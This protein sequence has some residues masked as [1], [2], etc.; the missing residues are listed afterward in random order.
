MNLPMD[1]SA[2]PAFEPGWVWLAG[3]GPG[4]VGLLTLLAAHGLQQADVVVYDALVSDGVMALARDDAVQIYA[5]KRGGRPS[6]RQQDISAQLIE[7]A[8]QGLRVLRLKGGDP[9]VFGR[10]GEEAQALGVAGIPFRI[11]PGVTAGIGALGTAGIPLTHRDVNQAV[12]FITGHTDNPEGTTSLDWQA[13]ARSAPVLVIYMGMRRLEAIAQNLLN[14]GKP[15]DEPVA[16]ISNATLPDQHILETTLSLAAQDA[17]AHG[18]TPPAIIVIGDVV[19]L[20][21][22]LRKT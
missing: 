19:P 14:A 10:G 7:R 1:F 13:L 6:C 4:D 12:T 18:L 3:A 21:T 2:F 15:P 11:I 16:I 17:S 20:R 8:K 5:G 22:H 9:F